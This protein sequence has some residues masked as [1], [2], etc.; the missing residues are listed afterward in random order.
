MP[1]PIGKADM[2]FNRIRAVKTDHLAE[3]LLYKLWHSS[4]VRRLLR[5]QRQRTH[6]LRFY[7]N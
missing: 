6:L 7:Q 4:L 2:G 1:S 3:N 5:C